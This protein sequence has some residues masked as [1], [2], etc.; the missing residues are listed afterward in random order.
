[1]YGIKDADGMAEML[2]VEVSG[3]RGQNI[4]CMGSRFWACCICTVSITS[5]RRDGTTVGGKELRE[6]ISPFTPIVPNKTEINRMTL[7]LVSIEK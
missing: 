3:S 2:V 6:K 1:M 7:Y 5:S 4:R